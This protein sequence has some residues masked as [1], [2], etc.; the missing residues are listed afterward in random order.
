MPTIQGVTN[1]AA[2][3]SNPNVLAGSAFEFLGYHAKVN[4]AIVGDAGG[5][6]RATVQSGT[7]VLL[8]ESPVSRAA[9]IPVW[10]DDYGLEDIAGAGDRL[11][12]AVRNVSAGALDVFW[13]VK[14]TP[15]V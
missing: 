8:E 9:R 12:I 4:I 2:G 5:N 7:D 13:A 3:A 10:P 15:L 14:V 11:K 1:I 6:F